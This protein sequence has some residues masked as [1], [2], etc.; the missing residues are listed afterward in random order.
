MYELRDL[1]HSKWNFQGFIH[2][3]PSLSVDITLEREYLPVIFRWNLNDNSKNKYICLKIFWDY[4]QLSKYPKLS[5]N[6]LILTT[7]LFL[8][9]NGSK[10]L[11]LSV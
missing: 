9:E 11:Y 2:E 7:F 10:N 1:G 6:N 5:A 8:S 4:L 3:R